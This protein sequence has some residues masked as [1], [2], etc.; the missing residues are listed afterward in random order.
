MRKL[1]LVPSINLSGP[2]DANSFSAPSG[3]D[4]H[5]GPF[6]PVTSTYPLE[7]HDYIS[8]TLSFSRPSLL[9]SSTVTFLWDLVLGH[10]AGVGLVVF[11]LQDRGSGEL[12]GQTGLW[13]TCDVLY[14]RLKDSLERRLRDDGATIKG[15]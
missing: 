8:P 4:W 14:T 15:P 5:L 9:R 10:S 6:L 7:D 1:C 12:H 11:P 3:E 13:P 2:R